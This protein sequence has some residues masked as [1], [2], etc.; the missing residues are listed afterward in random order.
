MRRWLSLLLLLLPTLAFADTA[1]IQVRNAW[2]R[3]MPAGAVGVVYLTATDTGPPDTL[4]GVASP[5]ATTASLH[6]SFSDS[7]VMK[8]RPVASLP[9]ADGKP[10]TLQPGGYHIM[11]MGLKQALVAGQSFPLTLN[12][13]KAGS[14]TVNV[15]VQAMGRDMPAMHPGDMPMPNMPMPNM[16]MPNTPMPNMPSGGSLK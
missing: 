12:F 8:M 6:E 15:A 5:I 16:P 7:G 11:L 13:A 3:A 4:F 14:I 1:P 2:S 9:I 10:I